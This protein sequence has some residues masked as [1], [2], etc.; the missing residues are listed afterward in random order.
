MYQVVGFLAVG[1]AGAAVLYSWDLPK[2][3]SLGFVLLTLIGAAVVGASQAR[4]VKGPSQPVS[5]TMADE[6]APTEGFVAP[7]RRQKPKAE[8]SI[9]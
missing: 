4:H 6:M 3:V 8:S 7:R 5:Y 1:A 9:W 2:F